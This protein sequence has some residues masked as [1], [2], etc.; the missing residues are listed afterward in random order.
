MKFK[1]TAAPWIQG[2]PL[3]RC[4]KDHHHQGPPDCVYTFQGWYDD[5]YFGR[6]VSSEPERREIIG[7]DDSGPILSFEDA[8]LISHAPEVPH[9]CS[10]PGCPGDL[11]RRKLELFGE[12]LINMEA[13]S[14]AEA[15]FRFPNRGS[16][17][18]LKDAFNECNRLI[19]KAKELR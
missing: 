4:M 13:L 8:Q 19:A 17:T 10:V 16:I 18:R 2:S 11:N 9:E 7:S 5:D 1:H 3:F 6:F 12:M 14:R 15:E